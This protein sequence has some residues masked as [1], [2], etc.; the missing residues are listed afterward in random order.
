MTI[1]VPVIGAVIG[2]A[3]GTMLYQIAKD[4]LSARE[5]ALLGEYLQST[6]QLDEELQA[7]YQFFIEGLSESMKQYMEILDRAFS[8]DIETAFSGSIEL[9]RE[10]GVPEDEILD[11]EEKILAFFLD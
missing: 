9:A 1:P 5:Q 7:K 10:M 2:N 6:R 4:N 8:P 3:V 11:T